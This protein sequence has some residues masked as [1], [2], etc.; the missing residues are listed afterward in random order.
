MDIFDDV[1]DKLL[2]HMS[3]VWPVNTLFQSCDIFR[4]CSVISRVKNS[5]KQNT[6]RCLRQL[7]RYWPLSTA[8][9]KSEFFDPNHE[10]IKSK[11][12][13]CHRKLTI[14]TKDHTIVA[15]DEERFSSETANL[16]K[17]NE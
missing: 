1:D 6:Q 13:M 3:R 7:V 2:W 11:T 16:L 5:N 17:N 4:Q 8:N 14:L 12:R 15:T 9:S 10:Y